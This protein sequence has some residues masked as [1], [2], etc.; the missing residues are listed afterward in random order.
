M[1]FGLLLFTLFL[2]SLGVGSLVAAYRQKLTIE[3]NKIPIA[4]SVV[5]LFVKPN[6][7]PF[8]T[9]KS[10]VT[11][12]DDLIVAKFIPL[13]ARGWLN[14]RSDIVDYNTGISKHHSIFK[15]QPDRAYRLGH[16][17]THESIISSHIDNSTH[18]VTITYMDT[19]NIT[20][21]LTIKK[22]YILTNSYKNLTK[23]LEKFVSN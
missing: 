11:V 6:L 10:R 5:R 13:Y 16:I 9:S 20:H 15:F 8:G 23:A 3:Q 12:Y 22:P 19:D 1:D 2:V 14:H 7:R 17:I 4:S 18:I 21:T